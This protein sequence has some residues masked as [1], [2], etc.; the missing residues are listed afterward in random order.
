[1][2]LIASID[3][4]YHDQFNGDSQEKGTVVFSSP[5][6]GVGTV[7]GSGTGSGS[8]NYHPGVDDYANY[9]YEFTGHGDIIYNNGTLLRKD[10]D[11]DFLDYT[12]GVYAGQS[13]GGGGTIYDGP[14]TGTFDTSSFAS[15]VQGANGDGSGQWSGQVTPTD[16]S[17]FDTSATELSYTQQGVECSFAMTGPIQETSDPSTPISNVQLFWSSSNTESGII[18]AASAN[19]MPIYWNSAG[20]TALVPLKDLVTPPS[21]TSYLLVVTNRDHSPAEQNYANNVMSLALADIAVQSLQWSAD[22]NGAVLTYNINNRRRKTFLTT[23]RFP[24]PTRAPCR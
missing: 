22:G 15:D 20:G 24:L 10:G 1:M 3:G 18:G 11:T 16:P 6:Y 21:G 14:M 9:G 5:T 8:D 17:P 12:S 4:P 13:S 7:A 23:R 19:V 2:G